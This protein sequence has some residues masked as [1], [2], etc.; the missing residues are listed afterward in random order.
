M[1][2]RFVVF[3]AANT[4]FAETIFDTDPSVTTPVNAIGFGG[5]V[6]VF[7]FVFVATGFGGEVC[8]TNTAPTAMATPN[9]A[10]AVRV[11]TRLAPTLSIATPIPD[12]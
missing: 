7:V 10:T 11:T 12:L 5:E 1:K 4:P 6:F 3:A 8:V 9:D 2:P